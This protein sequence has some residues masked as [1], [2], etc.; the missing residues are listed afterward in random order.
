MTSNERHSHPFPLVRSFFD[1]QFH[2]KRRLSSTAISLLSLVA[3]VVVYTFNGFT[4][5]FY[6]TFAVFL[7]GAATAIKHVEDLRRWPKD[8]GGAEI[9]CVNQGEMSELLVDPSLAADE[10]E[11]VSVGK[12]HFLT[13]HRINQEI[14]GGEDPELNVM[15]SEF[16][17]SH[18]HATARDKLILAKR[19]TGAKIFNG[20]KVRLSSDPHLSHGKLDVV[21][22]ERTN[23]FDTLVT[24]D[25]V[26]VQ[27]ILAG[28]HAPIYSGRETCFPGSVIPPLNAS[29]ASNQVGASTLA[30][31]NDNRLVLM[32]SGANSAIE[33]GKLASSG[34][35]SSD[36]SDTSGVQHLI[37]FVKRCALRELTEEI[38]IGMDAIRAFGVIGYGRLIDRGGKP[39][40]FCVSRLSSNYDE[41]KIMRPERKYMELAESPFLEPSST[42]GESV[43][44]T[45]ERI[46]AEREEELSTSL[47][48]N[49]RLV[50]A[51]N[52]EDLDRMLGVPID[53]DD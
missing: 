8:V 9:K 31:T 32:R 47:F 45:A 34:S 27:V 49:L 11:L 19:E 35:G 53:C 2:L 43:Q 3:S 5:S 20:G 44:L 25:A 33:I 40:F 22:V 48:W 29:D 26:D 14:S 50:V 21:R 7:G 51:C 15:H 52:S 12:R 10:Y 13:S 38:G 18:V 41:V 37:A 30:V 1:E 16:D 39:E 36:W 42:L 24:N 4:L 23:Y 28:R 17:V 46:L 6:V